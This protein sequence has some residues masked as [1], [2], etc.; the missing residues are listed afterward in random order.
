VAEAPVVEA[1]VAEARAVE[2]KVAEALV[3]DQVAEAR[4]V[5]ILALEAPVV[6][7][8]RLAHGPELAAAPVRL[9][10]LEWWPAW[11]V[12]SLAGAASR[13]KKSSSGF[14]AR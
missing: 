14:L 13:R 6:V 8:R 1:K 3:V 12:E 2:A 4:A 5:E 9:W 10:F 7:R 11:R